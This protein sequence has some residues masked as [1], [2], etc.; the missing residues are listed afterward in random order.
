M[1]TETPV[2][3]SKLFDLKKKPKKAIIIGVAVIVIIAAAV[4]LIST[5]AA[6]AGSGGLQ[7]QIATVAKGNISNNLEASGAIESATR[8]EIAPKVTSTIE[9]I[10]YSVGD[11]VK[12]G[13]VMFT[14]DDTDAL[15]SIEEI[16]NNIATTTVSLNETLESIASL[17]VTAPFA[18]QVTDIS[19]EEGDSVNSNGAVLT[20]TD[21]SSLSL[22][23]PF[24][25]SGIKSVSEGHKATLYLSDLMAS[26]DGTV[27]YISTTPYIASSGKQLYTVEITIKNPGSVAAGT[28]ASAEIQTSFGTLTSSESGSLEYVR[29]KVL[30]CK[31][32]GT[33]TD[34][35]VKKNQYVSKGAVLMTLEND[36]ME[37]SLNTTKLKLQSLQSQ[38]DIKNEQLTYYTLTAPCDGTILSQD[39]SPGDTVSHGKVVAVVADMTNLQF[40]VSI[41]E[42]DIGSIKV[43]QEVS[44]TADALEETST[45]P[46]TGKV[47]EISLEGASSNGVTTYPVT[48]SVDATELLKTGMNVNGTIVIS[49]KTDVLTVPLEAITTIDGK[50]YVYVRTDMNG[51]N[52]GASAK[53]GTRPAG[54]PSGA[55]PSGSGAASAGWGIASSGA[56]TG[57]SGAGAASSSGTGTTRAGKTRSGTGSAG[58][59]ASGS[60]SAGG[61]SS[62]ARSSGSKTGGFGS[63]GASSKNITASVSSDNYYEGAVLTEVTTGVNDDT[64]IEIVSGLTEGQLVVLPKAAVNAEQTVSSSK[65]QQQ[66][67]SMGGA[68]SGGMGGPPAGF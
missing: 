10:N 30:K 50:T 61:A 60:S 6:K 56:D 44:I 53:A 42:L 41:D 17:N 19:L 18:G 65:N 68:I 4:I 51:V 34:V 12:K 7:Q 11:Q 45:K 40:E 63:S 21:T 58:Y 59:A 23:V 3:I 26:V 28:T 22:T 38:L 14:L 1:K 35:N 5:K 67:R 31:A 25:G 57:S 16:N 15:L 52:N 48:I 43:G 33:V 27:T 64:N 39:V 2:V 49:S 37:T 36:S 32:G 8:K 66:N 54:A 24:S 46:L 20:L 47:K 29:S 55:A 9:S 13:D 62:G